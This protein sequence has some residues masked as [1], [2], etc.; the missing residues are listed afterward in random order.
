MGEGDAGYDGLITK[1]LRR[2]GTKG[3][4]LGLIDNSFQAIFKDRGIEIK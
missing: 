4:F 1:A 3:K 2:E